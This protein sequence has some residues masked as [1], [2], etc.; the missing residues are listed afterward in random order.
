MDGGRR[1]A[2]ASGVN[3]PRVGAVRQSPAATL[4]MEVQG[5]GLGRRCPQGG[6]IVV[7]SRGDKGARR[8]V[9]HAR[10]THAC[11][12]EGSATDDAGPGGRVGPLRAPFPS[13]RPQGYGARGSRLGR[14]SAVVRGPLHRRG[15]GAFLAWGGREGLE[16]TDQY[17]LR[18][19]G[20]QPAAGARRFASRPSCRRALHPGTRPPTTADPAPTPLFR[21][22]PSHA[23]RRKG[24]VV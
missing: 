1:A 17:L 18:P 3:R 16:G 2:V 4:W 20:G 8:G 6:S 23:S 13:P 12:G 9:V 11:G 15:R 24:R 22:R 7:S 14:P 21:P 19:G 5:L 10:A